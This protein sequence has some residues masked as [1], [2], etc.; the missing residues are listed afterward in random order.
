MLLIAVIR[1]IISI[2]TKYYAMG[3]FVIIAIWTAIIFEGYLENIR[4]VDLSPVESSTPQADLVL[5]QR[6]QV[7]DQKRQ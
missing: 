7:D 1:S 2:M 6:Q 3:L 5:K 4:R